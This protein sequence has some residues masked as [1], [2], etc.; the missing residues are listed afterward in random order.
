MVNSLLNIYKHDGYMPDA[1]SGNWNGRTQG[2]SNADIVIA[3]A[4]AKGM[5]GIDYEL[6]LKAMIKDAEVPPTDDDGFVGSV[7][8]EKHGQRWIDG[9]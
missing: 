7:P 4:F 2:G 9:I 8:E 5:K 1:R 3:D 6:A